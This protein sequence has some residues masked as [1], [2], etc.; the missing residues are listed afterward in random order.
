RPTSEWEI[1]LNTLSRL[2]FWLLVGTA[3][4]ALL[5]M[6]ILYVRFPYGHLLYLTNAGLMLALGLVGLIFGTGW[7]MAVLSVIG[8]GI[9][10][11]VITRNL[12][13]DFT[14]HEVRL[15]LGLDVTV[16]GNADALFQRASYYANLKMWGNAVLHLRHA[17][18]LKPHD[19]NYLLSL[20][21][22]YINIK[23][24][25]LAEKSLTDLEKIDPH[26]SDAKKLRQ[27]L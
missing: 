19:T 9:G 20:V 1:A 7:L 12:W 17:V 4:Y 22:A 27:A 24:S 5:L 23:R 21:V 3:L 2:S 18:G 25:D 10:Q 13:A 8:I 11:I 6:L 14:F 16:K 15:A 26:S